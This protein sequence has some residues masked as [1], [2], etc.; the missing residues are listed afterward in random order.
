MKQQKLLG[1]TEATEGGS[2]GRQD[3]GRKYCGGVPKKEYQRLP[4]K[5]LLALKLTT[6]I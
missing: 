5:P 4:E 2:D 3:S 1:S 6:V